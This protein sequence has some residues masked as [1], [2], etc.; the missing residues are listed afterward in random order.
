MGHIL[1]S[2]LTVDEA[3]VRPHPHDRAAQHYGA[4]ARKLIGQAEFDHQCAVS[5]TMICDITEALQ[6]D[7]AYEWLDGILR[8]LGVMLGRHWQPAEIF[9]DAVLAG[10]KKQILQVLAEEREYRAE[11]GPLL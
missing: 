1:D 8:I 7:V 2:M 4:M 6:S 10:V 9:N 3:G 11:L 5:E